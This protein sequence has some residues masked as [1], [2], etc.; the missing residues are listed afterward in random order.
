MRSVVIRC[1]PARAV[2]RPEL[3][4]PS[5]RREATDQREFYR[6][7]QVQSAGQFN[8]GVPTKRT[9]DETTTNVSALS[10]KVTPGQPQDLCTEEPIKMEMTRRQ[11]ALSMAAAASLRSSLRSEERRVGKE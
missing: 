11:F 6:G 10:G 7:R 1:S 2:W 8:V 4:D 3:R 9:V 5:V